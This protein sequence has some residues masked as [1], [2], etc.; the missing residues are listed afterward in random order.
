M[1]Y[2]NEKT[3]TNSKFTNKVYRIDFVAFNKLLKASH[4][5]TGTDKECI[6]FVADYENFHM[7]FH[8]EVDEIVIVEEF[9][10]EVDG[11]WVPAEPTYMQKLRLWNVVRKRLDELNSEDDVKNDD[12]EEPYY[13]KYNHT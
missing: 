3:F 12:Y 5:E 9:G 8:S 10:C 11:V 4:C 13:P 7:R 1:P 2:Q 6:G